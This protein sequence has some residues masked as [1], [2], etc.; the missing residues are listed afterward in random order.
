[1]TKQEE[2]L[3]KRYKEERKDLGVVGGISAICPSVYVTH[4]GCVHIAAADIDLIV[5][6]VVERL[7]NGS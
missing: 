3:E 6:L 5:N 7:G 1:M 4:N 2:I